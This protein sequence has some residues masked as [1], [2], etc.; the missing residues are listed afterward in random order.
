MA[1]CKVCPCGKKVVFEKINLAPDKCPFCGR[2]ILQAT[3]YE[4]NSE[5]AERLLQQYKHKEQEANV[6]DK[7]DTDDSKVNETTNEDNEFVLCLV[8]ENGEEIIIPPEGGIIG[9]TEI[10]AEKLANYPSISKQH[11][12][13]FYT[14]KKTLLIEDISRYGTFINGRKMEKNISEHVSP[15]SIIRLCNVDFTL[16][17]K[18]L[19]E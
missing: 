19:G 16:I 9:R 18:P 14:F 15:N 5:E 8:S 4:E 1:Y 11:I 6:I 7:E 12:K 3:R 13:V 17:K 2:L 10:G